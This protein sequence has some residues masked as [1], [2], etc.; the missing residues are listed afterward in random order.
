VRNLLLA[1]L[2]LIATAAAVHAA[3][4]KRPTPNERRYSIQVTEEMRRHS[5]IGDT[6]Y[7]VWHICE[8]LVLGAI[9]ATGWSARLRNIAARLVPW[10][11]ARVSVYFFLLSLTTTLLYFPLWYYGGFVVPHQFGLTHQTLPS[12]LLDLGKAAAVDLAIGMA[13]APLVILAM[14]MFKRWWIAIWLGSIPLMLAGFVIWPLFVDPLFNKFE[15]LQDVHLRQLLLNEASRAGIE[16][17][18]V[19]QVDK[20]KQTTEMNAYVT[21]IGPS[22]RIVLWDT[23]LAKLDDGEI[24]AVMGHEMGHYVLHHLWKG[25]SFAIFISL[26][27][28]YLA[29]F[30]FDRGV[31][32]WHLASER[33]DPA[34]LPLLLAVVSAITFLLSPAINGFSRYTEQEAD[35]FS[36]EL[37]HDNLAAAS[38]FVKF[39]ED[40]KVNPTPTPLMKW[41]R[42]SHPPL[43]ERVR[44]ALEWKPPAPSSP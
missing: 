38:S 27:T 7:G 13:L 21:G 3:P 11:Y 22:K 29:Q 19:Y 5:R 10:R 25:L 2:L 31:A 24:I 33:G 44:F 28:S 23:L 42:Y 36:L 40:S 43:D 39:A 34:A 9:L 14:R 17:G 26:I 6:L 35:V 8:F 4:I 20:S 30:F 37:T 16:G 15:P 41:W 18:R 12:W 32:R 1:A